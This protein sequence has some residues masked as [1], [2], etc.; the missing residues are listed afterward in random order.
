MRGEATINTTTRAAVG[1]GSTVTARDVDIVA[2][3]TNAPTA[4]VS[5]TAVGLVSAG[6][7]VALANDTSTVEAFVGAEAG[8][9]STPGRDATVT[10]TGIGNQLRVTASLES[11]V[12]STGNMLSISLGAGSKTIS[13]AR[14]QQSVRAYIGDGGATTATIGDVMIAAAAN[15][16][17]D[18]QGHCECRASGWARATPEQPLRRR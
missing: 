9:S 12:R 15:T 14:A 1:E 3:A 6:D 11:P 10:A 5:T 13:T 4:V 18:G 2:D 8:T 7:V 16:H 17:A